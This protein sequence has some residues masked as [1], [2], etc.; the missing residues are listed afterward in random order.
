[1]KKSTFSCMVLVCAFVLAN[2]AVLG[3]TQTA[4]AVQ[5]EKDLQLLRLNLRADKKKI[6]AANVPLTA[7]RHRLP[8]MRKD[9]R[10]SWRIT[11]AG[12]REH[13]VIFVT[14]ERSTTFERLFA[15]L[16]APTEDAPE[17]VR[18]P[19]PAIEV[20]R[21]IGGL[22]AEKAPAEASAI[23]NVPAFGT[24]LSTGAETASGLW[25][26]QVAFENPAP[27]KR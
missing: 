19:K 8:G 14:P 5:A 21:G 22:A 23:R 25:V 20:L 4:A 7:G 1:M 15:A 11:S 26:R 2:S 17:G 10:L 3:Q 16:P 24:P 12:V 6:L 13:F 27:R 9:E 18:L